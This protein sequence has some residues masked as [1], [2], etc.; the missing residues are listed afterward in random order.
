MLFPGASIDHS[1]F[2]LQWDFENKKY[3]IKTLPMRKGKEGDPQEGRRGEKRVIGK[4][5]GQSTFYT[6]MKMS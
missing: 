3:I 6:C 4:G 2:A 1:Q 5:I